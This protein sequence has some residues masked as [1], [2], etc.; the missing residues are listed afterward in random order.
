M[1]VGRKEST[2]VAKRGPIAVQEKRVPM[3][4]EESRY[5]CGFPG[6]DRPAADIY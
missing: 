4:G 1:R 5:F 2:H 3:V 6:Q